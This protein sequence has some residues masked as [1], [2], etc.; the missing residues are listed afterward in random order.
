[1]HCTPSL[2]HS[3]RENNSL[4]SC[5]AM[6]RQKHTLIKA[7]A[8]SGEISTLFWK[9]SRASDLL[10]CFSNSF[11]LER[12]NCLFLYKYIYLTSELSTD[13]TNTYCLLSFSVLDLVGRYPPSNTM[14]GVMSC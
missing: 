9:Q 8:I 10:P 7:S 6:A 13:K 3:Y 2:R 12:Y 1:M 4:E 5:V 14:I 11:P